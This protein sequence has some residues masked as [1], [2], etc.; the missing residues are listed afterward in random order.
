MLE[1]IVGGLSGTA[2]A[3][4]FEWVVHKNLMHRSS[5]PDNDNFFNRRSRK[6]HNDNHHKWYT[7][8]NFLQNPENKDKVLHIGWSYGIGGFVPLA[9]ASSFL[10]GGGI[11]SVVAGDSLFSNVGRMAGVFAS[12]IGYFALYE[13]VHHAFHV[14]GR[15]RESIHSEVASSLEC[16]VNG[17]DLMLSQPLLRR[18]DMNIEDAVKGLQKGYDVELNPR[19][20]SQLIDEL[21]H[22][23][24]DIYADVKSRLEGAVV[25]VRESEDSY[26]NSQSF[27]GQVRDIPGRV[28]RYLFNRAPVISQ[29][30]DSLMRH[31]LIHHRNVHVNLNVVLYVPDILFR[32]KS[33]SSIE[34]LETTPR[35][36]MSV[37]RK[38]AVLKS[39][40]AV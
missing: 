9:A 11:E 12:Q 18:L 29:A 5:S 1:V 26:R 27:S 38:T 17:S 22:S 31:H 36:W 25:A 6:S 3:S 39:D 20:I 10:I 24:D 30:Y 14:P 35:T 4:A 32:H 34:Y 33:D 13:A 2:F 16:Y 23:T 40:V 21:G 37:G 15:L 7:T 8:Q 19:I 28:G